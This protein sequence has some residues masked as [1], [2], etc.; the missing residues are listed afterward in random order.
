MLRFLERFALATKSLLSRNE[1]RA[2]KHYAPLLYQAGATPAL[3]FPDLCGQKSSPAWE[4]VRSVA[5]DQAEMHSASDRA[6][7]E[8]K[9]DERQLAVL[10]RSKSAAF[11]PISIAGAFVLPPVTLGMIEASATR[12]PST[13]RT[14]S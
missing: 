10:A 11:S 7:S 2:E 3:R 13:P 12:T 4:G 5:P 1:V 8:P 6:A 9:S 14:R